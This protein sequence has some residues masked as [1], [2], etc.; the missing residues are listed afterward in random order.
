MS[1]PRRVYASLTEALTAYQVP[2]ENHSLVKRICAHLGIERFVE[3]PAGYFKGIRPDGDLDLHIAFGYTNG[4]ASE[5]EAR[6]AAGE[7]AVLSPSSRGRGRWYAEHPT[8]QIGDQGGGEP[9]RQRDFGV[10][11]T[12]QMALPA[13]G[14]CDN[15]A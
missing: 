11:D 9:R 1:N 13:S 8:N 14:E 12:C 3:G 2:V 4:F 10:C 6:A 7:G 5:E 15:C